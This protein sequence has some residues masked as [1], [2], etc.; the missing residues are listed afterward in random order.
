MEPGL[1]LSRIGMLCGHL[2]VFCSHISRKFLK[3]YILDPVAQLSIV[4]K[5]NS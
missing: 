5:Q 1:N 4:D 3:E 2:L